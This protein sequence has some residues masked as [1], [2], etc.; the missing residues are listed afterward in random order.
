MSHSTQTTRILSGALAAF[1]AASIGAIPASAQDSTVHNGF[2]PAAPDS[3]LIRSAHSFVSTHV[4]DR[5][6]LTF[7]SDK[8][9]PSGNFILAC[10]LARA[11]ADAGDIPFIVVLNRSASAMKGVIE[12]PRQES[13]QGPRQ[14]CRELGAAM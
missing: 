3:I 7:R 11:G 5:G 12:L 2:L 10:G 13:P 14:K 6:P 9:I 4:K 8:L 1:V